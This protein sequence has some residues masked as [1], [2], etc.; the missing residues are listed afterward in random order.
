VKHR[1][2]AEFHK[3]YNRLPPDVQKLADKAFE[4]LKGDPSH[5]SLRFKKIAE[6]VW[7]ARVSLG[8]RA[9][10]YRALA[11]RDRDHCDWFWIGPHGEYERLIRS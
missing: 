7:A 8:H 5:P 1:R 6:D 9:L 10:G 11:L 2:T 4:L 3:H